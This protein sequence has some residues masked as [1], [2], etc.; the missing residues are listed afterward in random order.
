[1]TSAV[2]V[3]MPTVLDLLG[4]EIPR[5][6]QGRSHF[7]ER[8]RAQDDDQDEHAE[9]EQQRD[10]GGGQRRRAQRD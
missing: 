4:L 3:M 5:L 7:A 2:D 1:M 9:G 10:N 6:V 8:L